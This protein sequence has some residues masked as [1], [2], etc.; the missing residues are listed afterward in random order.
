MTDLRADAGLDLSDLDS[1]PALAVL[2]TPPNARVL[3]AGAGAGAVARALSERGSPVWTAIPDGAARAGAEAVSEGVLEGSLAELDLAGALGE[4]SLDAVVLLDVLDRVDDPLGLLT[5]L[6]PLL[7]S[8][9]KVVASV[10]NATHAAV[11]L[12]LL[13]G[14]LP[15]SARAAVDRPAARLFDRDAAEELFVAAG[16]RPVEVLSARRRLE[17]LDLGAE[18]ASFSE[19]AIRVATSGADADAYEFM[20]V[21]QAGAEAP[22]SASEHPSI[23]EQHRARIAEL[24]AALAEASAQATSLALELEAAQARAGEVERLGARVAELEEALAERMTE[25]EEAN[26]AAWHLRHDLLVK[27]RFIAELREGRRMAKRAGDVGFPT[28]AALPL[29]PSLF[30][31]VDRT[32]S[33]YPALRAAAKSA[34]RA[35]TRLYARAAGR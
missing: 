22:A 8:E 18:L 24:E 28:G 7:D 26:Q 1:P 5:R 35:A 17:E 3:V 15:S 25:L 14:E 30:A 33:R 10:P 16:L 6:R 27:E 19:D 20:V 4:R 13:R 12:R 32:L 2:A 34:Y 31:R 11:R 29:P 21:A 9:G 23:L